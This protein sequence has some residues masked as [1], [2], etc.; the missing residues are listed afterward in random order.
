[1]I[2]LMTL[3]ELTIPDV[4]DSDEDSVE[5]DKSLSELVRDHAE[6]LI[7][8]ALDYVAGNYAPKTG[9]STNIHNEDT[10]TIEFEGTHLCDYL[11]GISAE[12]IIEE[13]CDKM[14]KYFDKRFDGD[15][16]KYLAT[17]VYSFLITCMPA[18]PIEGS[19]MKGF[20]PPIIS[21]SYLDEQK[22][23]ALEPDANRWFFCFTEERRHDQD[24]PEITYDNLTTR[25]TLIRNLTDKFLEYSKIDKPVLDKLEKAF[26]EEQ[27]KQANAY[28]PPAH[29]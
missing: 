21:V 4:A 5:K 29:P 26:K 7:T 19:I 13:I 22:A 16:S 17:R 1:M 2:F 6:Y 23:G 15:V 12:R 25:P 10:K 3:A 14:G 27:S 11:I 28:Q 8:K 20:E 18:K 24:N 9:L